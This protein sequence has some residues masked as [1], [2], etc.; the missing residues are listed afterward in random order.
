MAGSEPERVS[1]RCEECGF[2]WKSYL[3]FKALR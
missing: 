1:V 3:K 2:Y